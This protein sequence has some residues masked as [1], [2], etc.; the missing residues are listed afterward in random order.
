MRVSTRVTLFPA[1]PPLGKRIRTVLFPVNA[2]P[3]VIAG[4]PVT[5]IPPTAAQQAQGVV[6]VATAADPRALKSFVNGLWGVD[7]SQI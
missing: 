5:P 7:W 1:S 3:T 4:L 2:I 6:T